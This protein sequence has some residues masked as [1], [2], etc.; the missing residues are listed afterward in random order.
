MVSSRPG[1]ADK[2]VEISGF[3]PEQV[4]EYVDKYFSEPEKE[5]TRNT[6][7]EHVEK[8]ENLVSFCHVPLLSFL[9][10]W[11][12]EWRISRSGITGKLPAKITDLYDEVGKVVVQ[13]LHAN[14]KYL[15]M[16]V[17]TMKIAQDTLG[18]LAKLAASLLKEKKYIFDEEDMKKINLTEDETANLKISGILHCVPGIRISAFETKS[19]FSF[20]HLTLQEFLAAS[21]FVETKEVPEK[22]EATGQTF[23]FMTGLSSR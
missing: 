12:L 21:F 7:R 20:L 23:V 22:E 11:C 18:K 6:V 17:N 8:N 4:T 10:C 9:L 16:S 2:H 1:E 5:Q 3:S 15:K 13:K 19:E 14:L